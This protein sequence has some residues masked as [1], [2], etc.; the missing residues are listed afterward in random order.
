MSWHEGRPKGAPNVQTNWTTTRI[1]K[2]PSQQ[3][4]QD[5]A[6]TRLTDSPNPG[7]D[8]DANFF[9]K[10]K[11]DTT[12]AARKFGTVS[13]LHAFASRSHDQQRYRAKA[14]CYD[15]MARF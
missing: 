12:R 11:S 15:K 4:Q 5:A 7:Q 3:E 8:Q 9:E 14:T 10:T 6:T 2:E 13:S 1:F